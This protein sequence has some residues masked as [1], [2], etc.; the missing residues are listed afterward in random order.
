MKIREIILWLEQNDTTK[1]I[2]NQISSNPR[3]TSFEDNNILN[4]FNDVN[5]NLNI[6]TESEK[7]EPQSKNTNGKDSNLDLHDLVKPWKDY[8]TILLQD[9]LILIIYIVKLITLGKY[10]ANQLLMFY[11]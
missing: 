7:L 2:E 8:E 10:A 5:S 1:L 3:I 11:V 6:F 9:I 4:N